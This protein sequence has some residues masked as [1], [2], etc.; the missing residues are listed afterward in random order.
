MRCMQ[1]VQSLAA[2]KS[3]TRYIH[4]IFCTSLF[5][6]ARGQVAKQ[7]SELQCL[8]ATGLRR[9]SEALLLGHAMMLRSLRGCCCWCA[10]QYVED[11]CLHKMADRLYSSLQ[12]ECDSHICS[13]LAKLASDH[14]MDPVLFLEKVAYLGH[15]LYCYIFPVLP[16]VWAVFDVFPVG[17]SHSLCCWEALSH[18]SIALSNHPQCGLLRLPVSSSRAQQSILL[19]IRRAFDC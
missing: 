10:I 1:N 13:Q 7:R 9:L 11:M 8:C 4:D 5:K 15:Y 3:F 14:T 18:F 6:V 12:R 2:W 16:K 19:G 17:R